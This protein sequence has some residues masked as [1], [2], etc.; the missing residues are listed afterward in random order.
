MI[1]PAIILHLVL[2]FPLPRLIT[3]EYRYF[4][5]VIDDVKPSIPTIFSWSLFAG[6]HHQTPSPNLDSTNNGRLGRKPANQNREYHLAKDGYCSPAKKN[7]KESPA[8]IGGSH[9]RWWFICSISVCFG[10]WAC[11]VYWDHYLH[12]VCESPK[13]YSPLSFDNVYAFPGMKMLVGA[14]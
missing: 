1:F 8:N 3:A 7:R 6:V 5:V 14:K 11:M 4:L 12:G 2:G 13:K 10:H 9:W